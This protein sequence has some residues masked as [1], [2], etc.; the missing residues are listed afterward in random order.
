MKFDWTIVS[1]AVVIMLA[2]VF[3]HA[4]RATEP[5]KF[6]GELEIPLALKI[7]DNPKIFVKKLGLALASELPKGA[8]RNAVRGK[9]LRIYN[10][11]IT[12]NDEL[13]ELDYDPR[14]RVAIVR[15]LRHLGYTNA[16]ALVANIEANGTL[17]VE[18]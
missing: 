7:R 16:K 10:L 11:V 13:E 6:F 5:T 15:A 1:I 4:Q 3:T 14:Q 9:I 17:P 8:K 2:G 18:E 12:D